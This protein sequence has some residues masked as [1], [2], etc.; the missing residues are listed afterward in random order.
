M[1]TNAWHIGTFFKIPVKIHWTFLLIIAYVI[2][3][4]ISEGA[5]VMI[6]AV[7][8]TSV[9]SLFLCVL[10]HEF[11][12]ALTARRYN[13][14]TEDIILLPIGGVARLRNMPDKP[15]KELVIAIMGP[16]VNL[17]I[18]IILFAVLVLLHGVEYFN[19][20][21]LTHIDESSFLSALPLLLEANIALIIFNMIP[22]FPM[23]GG[24]VLRAL[25]AMKFGKLKAT[26]WASIIGQIICVGF[27]IYG[28]TSGQY[29]LIVIGFF[30]FASALSEYNA[31]KIDYKYKDKNVSD[32][33]R[34]TYTPLIE[35]NTLEEAKL[36]IDTVTD[37]SFLVI[38]LSGQQCGT[39]TR[40]KIEKEKKQNAAQ[41]ISQVMNQNLQSISADSP[42]IHAYYLLMQGIDLLLVIKGNEIIGIV[43]QES[44]Q[45]A[46]VE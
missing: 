6:I 27:I 32:A 36:Q 8:I 45:L 33:V 12:H 15:I 18:A 34:N 20:T 23:D 42:L 24:R 38:N 17:V 4:G 31:V 41:R 46:T 37:N 3:Y 5:T 30:I 13:V 9:L 28:F 39:I 29:L 35:Y 26:K 43:D 40:S 2:G 19:T 14:E 44:L 16:M 10:L 22:S 7:A 25:L 1:F 21:N 11:G